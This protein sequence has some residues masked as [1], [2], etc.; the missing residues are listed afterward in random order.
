MELR[1]A[2]GLFGIARDTEKQYVHPTDMAFGAKFALLH[3]RRAVPDLAIML[4]IWQP[5]PRGPFASPRVTP[6]ARIAA[7]WGIGKH[8]G[9][10]FN[11]G[12]DWIGEADERR[13]RGIY[14]CNLGFTIPAWQN[15]LA[16]FAEAYGRVHFHTPEN[17]IHQIDAGA[18]LRLGPRWQLDIYSQHPIAK[19]PAHTQIAI[20]MS[21]RL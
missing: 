1:W 18:T 2:S 3:A 14:V 11:V 4:D 9:L 10:L 19:D 21:V 16:L 7:A 12:F 20:G 5:A 15:R 13:F 8:F 17:S 6:E